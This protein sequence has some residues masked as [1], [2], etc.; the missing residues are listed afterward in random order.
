[1]TSSLAVIEAVICVKSMYMI[2]HDWKSE[3][4]T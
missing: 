1:V 4:F 2:Y 3:N